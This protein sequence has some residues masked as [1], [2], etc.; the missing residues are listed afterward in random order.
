MSYYTYQGL[1]EWKFI[2]RRTAFHCIIV[3]VDTKST[4]VLS[5]GR[6]YNEEKLFCYFNR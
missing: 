2:Q 1:V 3:D 4:L 5:A 6:D